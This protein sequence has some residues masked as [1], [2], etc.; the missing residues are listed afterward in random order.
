MAM[1]RPPMGPTST[2]MYIKALINSFCSCKRVDLS[3]MSRTYSLNGEIV[4]RKS[5]SHRTR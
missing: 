4:S 1:N 3:K 5:F 2:V